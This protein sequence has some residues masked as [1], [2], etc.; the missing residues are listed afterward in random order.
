MAVITKIEE[1]KNKKRVN[2]F[3]DDAFFCGLLKETA[4]VFGLKVGKQVNEKQLEEAIFNSEVKRAFEKA[5]DYIGDRMHTKKELCDKLAKKGFEKN[6]ANEAVKKLEEYHYVDDELFAKH[7]VNDNKKYSKKMLESKLR[8]KGV[9]LEIIST[10]LD[11]RSDEDE[12]EACKKHAQTY[13]KGKD[14][15]TKEGKQKLFGSLARRGYG[16][17]VIKKAC[18]SLLDSDDESEDFYDNDL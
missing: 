1:Q 11:F 9:S 2:I 3:V 6:V 15:R 4:V 7:F 13:A 8:Q 18:K 10:V 5:S 12:I 17:D 14:I 16:F